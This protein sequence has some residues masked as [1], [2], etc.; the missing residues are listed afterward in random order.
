MDLKQQLAFN[1]IRPSRFRMWVN[2]SYFQNREERLAYNDAACTL[3]QYW[4]AYK[5]WLKHEYRQHR[6][7]ASKYL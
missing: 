5:W 2:N 1:D 7:K 6:V 4:N 3:Q